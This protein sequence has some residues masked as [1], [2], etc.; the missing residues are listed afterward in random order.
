MFILLRS[1]KPL[2]HIVGPDEFAIGR[3]SAI[4]TL[5]RTVEHDLFDV[6]EGYG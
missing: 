4:E 3:K 1:E 2:E 6:H 5:K